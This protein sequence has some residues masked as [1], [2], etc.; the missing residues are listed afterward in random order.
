MFL[1]TNEET[2]SSIMI[3]SSPVELISAICHTMSG[4]NERMV[5]VH[6]EHGLKAASPLPKLPAL[7]CACTAPALEEG[8]KASL[9]PAG[10]P[11]RFPWQIS[12]G[13]KTSTS[14]RQSEASNTGPAAQRWDHTSSDY[15]RLP[16]WAA[17][18]PSVLWLPVRAGIASHC[19]SLQKGLIHP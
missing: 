7:P 8:L 17:N 1:R 18:K 19:M 13:E 15:G 14:G 4:S 9:Y 5:P 10:G 2:L 12:S 6:S 3:L 11:R 16:S